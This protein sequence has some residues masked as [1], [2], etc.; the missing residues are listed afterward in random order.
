M[1]ER[2]IKFTG[3]RIDNGEWVYGNL[4]YWIKRGEKILIIGE[5]VQNGSVMGFEVIPESVGQYSGLND[6][7]GKGIYEGDILQHEMVEELITVIF[8]N[9]AFRSSINNMP[10]GSF[11]LSEIEVIGNVFENPE[12]LTA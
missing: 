9:G 8:K 6:K 2:E 11:R 12:L 7:N 4:F 3:K 5:G 1:Q 10:I